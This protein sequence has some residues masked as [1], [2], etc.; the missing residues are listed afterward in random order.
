MTS[1]ALLAGR[2]FF[3]GLQKPK[4]EVS[5]VTACLAPSAKI[6]SANPTTWFLHFQLLDELPRENIPDHGYCERS[7]TIMEVIRFSKFSQ[8]YTTVSDCMNSSIQ[9]R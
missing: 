2:N 7:M 8:E 5:A 6:T 4:R 1:L 3:L 9:S